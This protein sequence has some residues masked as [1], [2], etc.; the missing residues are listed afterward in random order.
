MLS[1]CLLF[2]SCTSPVVYGRYP[3]VRNLSCSFFFSC[4]PGPLVCYTD[5]ANDFC[6]LTRIEGLEVLG[7]ECLEVRRAG[8]VATWTDSLSTKSGLNP[9]AN[10]ETTRGQDGLSWLILVKPHAFVTPA[11]RHPFVMQGCLCKAPPCRPVHVPGKWRMEAR[12]AHGPRNKQ[13]TARGKEKCSDGHDV[14]EI[15]PRQ[16]P[17]SDVDVW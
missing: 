2:D 8:Y 3:Y 6:L 11:Q 5:R 15:N 10:V 4:Y 13:K 16:G 1:D 12:H 7:F 17:S 9:M 14:R